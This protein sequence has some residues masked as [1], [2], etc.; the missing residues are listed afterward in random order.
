MSRAG[1]EEFV[2]RIIER[3]Q[4]GRYSERHGLVT[5]Y[6]PQH[7]M[8]KVAFQP[9]G[10]E[11]GWLPIETGHIGQ[12]YGIAIGLQ[13]G[14]GGNQQASTG[15]SSGGSGTTSQA[16]GDQVIVRYQESNTWLLGSVGLALAFALQP[17]DS[18][19]EVRGACR[20]AL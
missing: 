9:E 14:N 20:L 1:L 15:S 8:A 3:Y 7:H 4:A 11:L 13:P 19:H 12:G 18:R 17:D 2:L 6:D 5:S 16:T 10:Q